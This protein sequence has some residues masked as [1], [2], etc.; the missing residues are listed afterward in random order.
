[1]DDAEMVLQTLLAQLTR[2]LG[3]S[4][5]EAAVAR[6]ERTEVV[7]DLTEAEEAAVARWRDRL[8]RPERGG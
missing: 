6:T 2:E 4:R 3:A 8:L 1:M 5:I 7:Q